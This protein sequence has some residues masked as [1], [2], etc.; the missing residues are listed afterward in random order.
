M[1]VSIVTPSYFRSEWC[2]DE[3]AKFIE[4]AKASRGLDVGNK[5]RVV[6][7]AKTRVPLDQ[8]PEELRELLEFRFYVEEP[9]GTAR[10][11]HLSS[12]EQV[13]KRFYTI[14][15]DAAQAIEK[16]LRGLETGSAPV[17]RGSVYL[18]ETSSDIDG[19]RDQLRRSLTQ[20]GYTRVAA[21]P[22]AA[23]ERSR[24]GTDRQERP[25][26]MPA[27][28][29]T[30]SARTTGLFQSALAIGRS[31]SCNSTPPSAMRRNGTLSRMVWVPPGITIAEERQQRLLARIR[32]E[33]PSKGFEIIESPLTEIE[34]HIKDRL[35]RPAPALEPVDGDD[36]KTAPRSICS[37]CPT[38]RDAAR[39]VRDCL[40]N[41]GF[42]VRLPP[43]HRRRRGIVAHAAT[44]IRR[45]LSR[46][47]GQRGRRVVGTRPDRTEESQGPPQGQTDSVQSGLSR[48][49]ANGRE[50]RFPDARRP[51][52]CEAFRRRRSRRLCS[53]CSP[54]SGS[55]RP[56]GKP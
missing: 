54:S 5:S 2:N 33:L 11:F 22:A 42:E 40:F 35:E 24:S 4:R 23:A 39:T 52:C 43:D 29:S 46:L 21:G 30:P 13:Q 45:R 53:R 14:V 56:G 10:E 6:K 1:L 28:L 18:G 8:Y 20:R 15:D 55:A 27:W 51:R 26:A 9:N 19:E 38:D 31:P 41:E 12:D 16:I 47:L 36:A 48:G 7:A 34:T 3:R 49:S 17:S 50:A 37:A 32:T 44:G 25:R